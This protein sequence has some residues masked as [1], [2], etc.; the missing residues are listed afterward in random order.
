MFFK[1]KDTNVRRPT[2]A[3]DG[4][5]PRAARLVRESWWLL[6]VVGFV[7]LALILGSYARSD[8]GWSFSGT[9]APL[10]NRGG[11]IG[12]WLADLMLYLFGL[13]AW[14]W[15]AGGVVLVLAG[16][17]RVVNPDHAGDQPY[18]LGALGFALVL[19]G[20][21]AL[22]SLRLWSLKVALPHAPGGMLGDAIGQA[23]ARALGFNGATLLLL[24][25]FAIGCS[26]FFG[27]SWLRVMERIGTGAE[28][29]IAWVRRRREAAL[30]RRP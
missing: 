10:V 26:L 1:K 29:L 8:P 20:S 23:L 4:L 24:A 11:A 12:A 7:Y 18:A 25:L 16:F 21:A 22:E 2:A 5:S 13:S 14:W 28:A 6:V 15:V 30:D 27:V 17:R 3:D 19:C 9:G